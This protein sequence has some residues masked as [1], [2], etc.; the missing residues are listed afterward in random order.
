MKKIAVVLSGCGH[1]DGAE[2]TESVS[3]LI[4]LS[5]AGAQFEVFA[6]DMTL[7]VT[8]PITSQPTGEQRKLLVE[9]ARIARGHIH[10]LKTLKASRFDGIAFPGGFGVALNLCS[11][12]QQG[13]ACTV[14]PDVERVIREFYDEKKPILAICISPALI[15]RVLG[16]H[17]VT[18][19]I[20]DAKDATAE[21][22]KKTGAVHE[23]CAVN[24]FVTDREHRVITTPAYMYGEAKPS[25]VFTGIRKAVRELVEMA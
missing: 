6:P 20:G 14:N 21:E 11:W 17:G 10:D 13:S 8:D 2:I 19:T 24:D 22:I 7:K 23:G 15:A 25:E 5:E 1:K 16:S 4:A 9:A 3:T 18:V 12:A